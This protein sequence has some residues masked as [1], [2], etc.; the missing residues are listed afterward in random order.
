VDFVSPAALSG[1]RVLVL[2]L[3]SFGGGA[4]ACRAL[5]D[6]GA[7]VTVTDLRPADALPE[8]LRS[9]RPRLEA[10][11]PLHF[12]LGGHHQKLFADAEVV[13]VN[14]AV[15]AHSPWL[16]VARNHGCQLTTEVN[17][18]LALRPRLPTVA[19]TGTHGKSTCAAL[20]AHFLGALPGR[21]VLGGN[22]GGSLLEQV[23]PLG[24]DDRLVVELSSFQCERLLAPAAWPQVA[25]L[26]SFGPD[27]L[28]RHGDLETYAACKRRLLL[29]QQADNQLLLPH[30]HGDPV[31][32]QE[33]DRWEREARGMA[34]RLRPD[35]YT[36]FGLTLSDLPFTEPYRMPS[37]LAALHAAR[38]LTVADAALRERTHS[39]SGLPH[40]MHR[41]LREDGREVI[42]NG[43]A[44]HPT[45]TAAA[46]R[47]LPANTLLLAGGKDKGL[48]LAE[49]LGTFTAETRLYLYGEGGRRLAQE[50]RAQ[51]HPEELVKLFPSTEAAFRT[52]L[53][54][55]EKEQILLFSPTFSS[56]DE[57]LNF[58]ER[59]RLFHL[60]G[61]FP[62]VE[63]DGG[64]L[65]PLADKRVTSPDS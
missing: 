5:L 59:A 48:D 63:V 60:L 36:A 28:D 47:H 1:R 12:A 13:V 14:P 57:F 32:D 3:G 4:G 21:T 35:G 24:A 16:E 34:Q 54:E 23:M 53:A 6:L 51:G 9:L 2:G 64:T 55:Q 65:R 15:P 46:L 19:I 27:H 30:P 17:L 26:T 38:L 49:V 62:T 52:A 44:T 39:F 42:D 37:L 25:I 20:C 11:E 10:G 7:E 40:R 56:Y 45:P 41:L 18:A 43:V 33:V 61:R 58:A 29:A 50:A 31:Q 22:L 8:A